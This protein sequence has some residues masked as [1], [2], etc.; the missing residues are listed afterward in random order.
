M[1]SNSRIIYVHIFGRFSFC[2]LST[3]FIHI[4]VVKV[5]GRNNK[6]EGHGFSMSQPCWVTIF[7]AQPE[8]L[9]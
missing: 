1:R 3:N 5:G 4:Q 2:G 7:V 8:I 9:D 6:V